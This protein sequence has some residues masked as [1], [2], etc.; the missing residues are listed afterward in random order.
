MSSPVTTAE[1]TATAEELARLMADQ[2]IG[3]VVLLEDG[4]LLGIVTER[5]LVG[6]VLAQGTDP[7][8]ARARDLMSIP[9]VTIVPT[10]HIDDALETMAEHGIR[11]LIVVLDDELRGMVTVTDIA[12]TAMELDRRLQGALGSGWQD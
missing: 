7:A 11:H 2:R 9:P 8:E 12:Q 5:D 10:A 3:S 1:A 4:E 6:K